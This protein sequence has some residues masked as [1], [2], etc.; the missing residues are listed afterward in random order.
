MAGR[1]R[2]GLLVVVVMLAVWLSSCLLLV[3]ASPSHPQTQKMRYVYAHRETDTAIHTHAYTHAHTQDA[4]CTYTHT[5]TRARNAPIFRTPSPNSCCKCNARVG[6]MNPSAAAS[7]TKANA[8]N[9][10][11]KSA[12]HGFRLGKNRT[13]SE[14]PARVSW[15]N[16]PLPPLPIV[17]VSWWLREG[18]KW[19]RFRPMPRGARAVRNVM[20]MN[21]GRRERR[22]II[23]CRPSEGKRAP[24]MAVEMCVFERGRECVC[25]H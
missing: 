2:G 16:V 20:A 13:P 18:R 7:P 23:P 11:V 21:M 12:H 24:P 15:S 14:S 19:R 3:N 5:H 1:R 10:T 4:I 17:F 22:R 8:A 9:K 6:S 25:V